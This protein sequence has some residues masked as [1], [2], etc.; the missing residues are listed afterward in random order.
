MRNRERQNPEVPRLM[1]CLF[2]DLYPV[3]K[4]LVDHHELLKPNGFS[5]M[6]RM[7]VSVS[8]H[9]HAHRAVTH[10]WLGMMLQ[11]KRDFAAAANAYNASKRRAEP[12]DWQASFRLWRL[13]SDMGDAQGAEAERQQLLRLWG[14]AQFAWYSTDTH[15]SPIEFATA[16]AGADMTVGV[17]DA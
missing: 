11:A 1:R 8:R 4:L 7:D 15:G 17:I 10:L 2:P 16:A 14:A 13:L 3:R 6:V 12:F 9:L 5:E